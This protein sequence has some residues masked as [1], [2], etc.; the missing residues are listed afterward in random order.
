[1]R[2]VVFGLT[3]GIALM[4]GPSPAAWADGVTIA[5][6]LNMK[7]LTPEGINSSP[8]IPIQGG[9]NLL[10][11]SPSMLSFLST[12]QL[13][14]GASGDASVLQATNADGDYTQA[15]I[16]MPVTAAGFDVN[17]GLIDR[18][19]SPSTFTITAPILANVTSGGRLSLSGLKIDTP[20]HSIYANV[21]GGNGYGIAVNMPIWTIGSIQTAVTPNGSF[22]G[23]SLVDYSISLSNLALTD[24]A[25]AAFANSL[26]LLPFGIS[27]L[28]N[29][30]D[31]GTLTAHIE[32]T[33]T[34]ADFPAAV[35]EPSTFATLGLGLLGIGW[36]NRRRRLG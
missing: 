7:V 27:A 23:L 35:P 4:V 10:S 24:V 2:S 21:D 33:G 13:T 12:G 11:V 18:V 34:P 31:S 9:N 5:G 19:N 6:T 32:L 20:S 28:N 17:T 26:G 22:D 8:D 14:L 16:N 25:R 1:M 29:I 15:A 3:V 30:S 36:T